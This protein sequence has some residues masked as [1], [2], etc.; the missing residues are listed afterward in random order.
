MILPRANETIRIPKF[1]GRLVLTRLQ[2]YGGV[3]FGNGIF[4]FVSKL[5]LTIPLET[6]LAPNSIGLP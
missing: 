5:R 1:K 4:C 6:S 3:E 2:W